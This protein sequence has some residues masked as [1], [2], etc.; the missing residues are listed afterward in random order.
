[1]DIRERW[2]LHSLALL[3]NCLFKMPI[4]GLIF[5]LNKYKYKAVTR[6]SFDK[7]VDGTRK[8]LIILL[9]EKFLER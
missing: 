9:S 1:M 8:R 6:P 3:F 7:M 5:F 2:Q 4:Y